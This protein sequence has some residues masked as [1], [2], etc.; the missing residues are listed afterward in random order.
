MGKELMN[1]VKTRK[2]ANLLIVCLNIVVFLYLSIFVG[3]TTDAV[4]MEA[5]GAMFVP[6]VVEKGEYY[7]LLTS[8]FLHFGIAHLA[9]NM[10]LLIFSGDILTIQ[11][12]TVRYLCIY[13][14]GGLA[15]N[16]LSFAVNLK[17]ESYVVSAGASG[18][19]FAVIGALVFLV[20]IHKG[21][22]KDLNGRGI[23]A[24]AVLSLIQG[25]TD[26]GVDNYAHLGGFI[27]GF[28]LAAV[29]QMWSYLQNCRQV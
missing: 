18:A 12:G 17:A 14:G 20:L 22:I 15:G 25:F 4:L 5:H 28:L 21:R 24:M 11:V 9:F 3:S 16:L 29:F 13:L 19:I 1:F 27:G 6:D 2:K 10:L 23:C 26:S 8:M 7:R